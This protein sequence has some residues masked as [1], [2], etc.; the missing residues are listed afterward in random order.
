M[1]QTA[2]TSA[3]GAGTL[4]IL[5]ALW[6]ESNPNE[7]PVLELEDHGSYVSARDHFQTRQTAC[8][9]GKV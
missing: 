5:K 2:K 8:K 1:P 7:Q 9:A 6:Q 4:S 3:K